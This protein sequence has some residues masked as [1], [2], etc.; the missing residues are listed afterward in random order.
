[1]KKLMG[2]DYLLLG[3]EAILLLMLLFGEWLGVES[4]IYTEHTTL[5]HFGKL[6]SDLSSYASKEFFSVLSILVYA[7]LI[8]SAIALCMAAVAIIKAAE[9]DNE[10]RVLNGFY[11]TIAFA[12]FIILLVIIG[13]AVVKSSSDGWISSIFGLTATPFLAIILSVG[14]VATYRYSPNTS[15]DSEKDTVKNGVGHVVDAGAKETIACLS[16]GTKCKEGTA[17]CPQC[18]TKLPVAM[19]RICSKCSKKLSAGVKFCP[20]C[21]TPVEEE[22]KE[23]VN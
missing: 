12:A 13:N 3:L 23:T 5:M 20:N 7:G 19:T 15:L 11:I 22:V 21:G 1:M 16:C 6:V 9:A 18:G 10:V 4:F 8:G 14:G 2:K 17:F